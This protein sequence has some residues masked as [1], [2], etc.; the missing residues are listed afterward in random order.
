[1][2]P[3]QNWADFVSQILKFA[4]VGVTRA[5]NNFD[6]RCFVYV[7]NDVVQHLTA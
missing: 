5:A 1:L 4:D 7:I 6:V 2:E 3:L